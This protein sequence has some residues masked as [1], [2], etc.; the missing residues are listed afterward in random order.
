MYT[1]SST[2]KHKSHSHNHT[3]T[4]GYKYYGLNRGECDGRTG[5]WYREWA[6][7]AKAVALVGEFNDWEPKENHWAV[8]NEFGTWELFLPDGRDGTPMIWHR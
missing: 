3:R 1:T 4:T 7:A 2:P 5:V 6:P 8:R